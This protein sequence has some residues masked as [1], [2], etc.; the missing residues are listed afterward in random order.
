MTNKRCLLFET[1]GKVSDLSIVEGAS[2]DGLM[3]LS[4]V[5]GVCGVRNNNNRIYDKENYRQ[6]VESLQKVIKESGC[7]G[8]LEHP[9]SMNINLENV[10]HKIEDIQM[11]E[12]GTITG[13]IVLLNTPK[14]QIAQ[15]IVEGGLPLF[16]SSRAAG[17]MTNES[18]VSHVTLSTIKTY[19]LVGTPGFSQ[20]KLTLKENQT[21]ECLN[22]SADEENQ[23]WA[24]VEGDDPLDGIDDSDD[25]KDDKKSEDKSKDDS[26]DDK[27]EEKKE[28]KKSED[29]SKEEKKED[30][31]KDL[32]DSK[33]NNKNTDNKNVDMNDLKEA[34]DKLADKV[35][36]LEA[37]LH[38]AQE[39]VQETKSSIPSVNYDAIQTWVAE[40]FG[41]N[42]KDELM[43]YIDEHYDH[44]NVIDEKIN[45][46]IVT[47]SE[48]VQNWA[49]EEFAPKVQ[50]WVTEEF[51]PEVQNWVTEE[52]APKVQS[53]VTE[54]FA[55]EVQGWITEEYSPTIQNWITEE[56]APVID[57]W[58]TEEYGPSQENK[59]NENVS[60]FLE[61]N[62]AGRLEEI[63]S[64][65]E[66]ISA[67]NTPLQ[68][69]VKEN[70][71]EEKYKGMFVIE[72]MP[73]EYKP[74]WEMLDDSRKDSIVRASRMYD[75]TKQGVLES[76]WANQDLTQTKETKVNENVEPINAYHQTIF[77]QMM[78][79]RK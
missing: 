34:I 12:D 46:A 38:I 73:S 33:D 21:L 27:K 14:G 22:E 23:V 40:E 15:A 64:L 51:A 63:D 54:E 45:D 72:Y 29:D 16:I 2:K 30:D 55:P 32:K 13:T 35:T 17:T 5:F 18:G 59:I 47:I 44:E 67:D 42:F 1:L 25:K 66:T 4:G 26:K 20:A 11:N 75:F 48:G 19:D 61:N 41:P 78:R 57:N 56:F 31:K 53:W 62:K 43:T 60:A 52:F 77:Q 58:I 79:L 24:I 6:M 39:S 10:S 76:F 7:P 71:T 8:E 69:I 49:T 50:S 9:N 36:S 37:E 68:T 70:T 74:L 3:R 65:L 28:D